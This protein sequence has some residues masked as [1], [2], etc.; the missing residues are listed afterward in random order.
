VAARQRWEIGTRRGGGRVWRT[1]TGVPIAV[2][3]GRPEGGTQPLE[4][5]DIEI[6]A[7]PELQDLVDDLVVMLSED[8]DEAPASWGR[9]RWTPANLIRS[10]DDARTRLWI[11]PGGPRTLPPVSSEYVE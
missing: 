1:T 8:E 5:E 9:T 2:E 7:D 11:R 3:D 6:L 10:F 4:L